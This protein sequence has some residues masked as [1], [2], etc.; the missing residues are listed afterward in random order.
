[1]KMNKLIQLKAASVLFSLL[2]FFIGISSSFIADYYTFAVC[3]FVAISG[4]LCVINHPTLILLHC[5]S[6]VML[7]GYGILVAVV[8]ALNSFNLLTWQLQVNYLSRMVGLLVGFLF[9]VGALLFG[10]IQMYKQSKGYQI[11]TPNVY[12]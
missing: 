5:F 7:M 11:K 12:V 9:T 2:L 1:M 10:W 4:L 3:I 8:D 6:L